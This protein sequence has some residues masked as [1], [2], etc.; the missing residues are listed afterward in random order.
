MRKLSTQ[1]LQS[2]AAA[3]VPNPPAGL[4]T[5]FNDGN[6]L[7]VKDSAGT[8]TSLGAAGGGGNDPRLLVNAKQTTDQNIISTTAAD[9]TGL[10]LA[11]AANST[12]YVYLA[13]P[14]G[15]V[16]GTSPTLTLSFTGP[17]TPTLVS[18]RRRQMTTATAEALSVITSFAA[19]AAGAAVS[20]TFHIIEGIIVTGVNAGTLQLRAAAGGTVPSV[21]IKAGASIYA[22][23]TV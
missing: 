9:V 16:T 11:L 8:V 7:K 10:S 20:N 1:Q 3:N 6:T 2:I 15:T 19:F 4:L 17:A 21:P 14:I 12:Y 23:K 13:I 5:L 22:I 18:L